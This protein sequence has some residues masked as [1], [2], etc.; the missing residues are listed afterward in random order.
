MVHN[1]TRQKAPYQHLLSFW[2]VLPFWLELAYLPSLLR[3]RH[4]LIIRL[5]QPATICRV[6]VCGALHFLRICT[7]SAANLR[8][9]RPASSIWKPVAGLRAS[10]VRVAVI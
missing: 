7:S 9:K 10:C 5:F 3:D 1:G 8:L 4:L 6:G 2:L